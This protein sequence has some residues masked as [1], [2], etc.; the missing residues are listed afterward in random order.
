MI[1]DWIE[2]W[3]R[4]EPERVALVIPE[5]R[6]RWSYADLDA[7]I[8][9]AQAWLSEVH[10]V[11]TGDR[12]AVLSRNRPE[13]IELFF[14]CARLGA[15]LVPINWRLAAPEVSFVLGDCE[16]RVTLFEAE[17]APADAATCGTRVALDEGGAPWADQAPAPGGARRLLES[18]PV[19]I[20]YTSGTTGS[21]KGAVL[22]HGS[23]LWNSLNTALSWDLSGQDSTLTHTPLFHTGGWNVLTTPLLHRGG[24]VV[25]VRAFDA[26][27]ALGL[28]D[29]EGLSLVFAVPTMFE[30]MI[31]AD[32]FASARLSSLRYFISGGAPCPEEVGRV[33]A[34][35]GVR[36][37]QGYGLTEVGPN[38]FAISLEDAARAPGSVGVPVH[39]EEV[40]LVDEAGEDVPEGEVG[41]ILLRG[42]HMCAGYWRR[43][44][45]TAEAIRGGWFHTGDLARRDDRGHYS[46]VGR[47]KEMFISGGENV[48]P[49]EVER[50][51]LQYP[52]VRQAAVVG[53]PHAR[54]GEV[55]RAFLVA[56]PGAAPSEEQLVEHCR[57]RLARYK[58][59]KRFD[60][61]G[62]LPLT[63]SGKIAKKELSARPL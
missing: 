3:S 2:R 37:K 1:G 46:I 51:L 11:V 27:Q 44:D 56:E 21:P 31:R 19:M 29:S 50:V 9:R 47:R 10:G 41:E 42:P 62:E 8:R 63:A 24:K 57:A 23:V 53:I 13:E 30:S 58:V 15:I 26:D 5:R 4:L 18:T 25:L 54:W 12:V 52:G 60:V 32:A 55:G 6:A 7:G 40:R 39:H 28:I 35:R 43:P 36:F 49:A 45:A 17:F 33:F 14:A 22:T 38:C 61:V 20:L 34:A 16:P 48:Y 59:P